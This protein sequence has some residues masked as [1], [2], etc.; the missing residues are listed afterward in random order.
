MERRASRD[1]VGSRR[2]SDDEMQSARAAGSRRRGGQ[3]AAASSRVQMTWV[4][5]RRLN[6]R[7]CAAD[8]MVSMVRQQWLMFASDCALLV[9][10]GGCKDW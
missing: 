6:A 10:G 8:S 9:G 2:L 5:S 1:M 7:G 3:G 4:G